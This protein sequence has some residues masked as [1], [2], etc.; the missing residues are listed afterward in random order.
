MP[1]IDHRRSD[2]PMKRQGVHTLFSLHRVN[3]NHRSLAGK[4]DCR[5]DRAKLCHIEVTLELLSRLPFFDEQQGLAP[6]E[7]RVKTSVLAAGR[8]PRGA[9]DGAESAQ[10]RCSLFIRGHNMH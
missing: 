9:E 2:A 5:D 10:Q 7:I 4:L 6:V 3:A 1:V 8:N